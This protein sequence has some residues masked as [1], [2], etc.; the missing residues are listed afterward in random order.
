M[1]AVFDTAAGFAPAAV[2]VL[3]VYK[4]LLFLLLSVLAFWGTY[5][6]KS[7]SLENPDPVERFF[8]TQCSASQYAALGEG[9]GD[10]KLS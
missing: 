3:A 7:L 5:E 2:L 6:C 4:G 8:N 10:A 1:L 9:G